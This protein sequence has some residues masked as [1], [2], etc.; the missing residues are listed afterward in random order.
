[1]TQPGRGSSAHD[2]E[3]ERVLQNPDNMI[4]SDSL[5]DQV[6]DILSSRSPSAEFFAEFLVGEQTLVLELSRVDRSHDKT[7]IAGFC[8]KLEVRPVISIDPS[9]WSLV[10]VICGEEQLF[11]TP[12]AGRQL[13]V[14]YDMSSATGSCFVTV[15]C[16]S[17]AP[18]SK[19]RVL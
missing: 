4:V 18:V 5:R 10:R 6:A 17:P 14:S 11:E 7:V 1:M 13:E 16:M 19:K 2:A 12:L 3:W 9:A 8:S 15:A